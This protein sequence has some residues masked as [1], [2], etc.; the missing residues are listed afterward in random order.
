MLSA[1]AAEAETGTS[2]ASVQRNLALLQARN[3][4]REITGQGRF[5]VWTA[6]L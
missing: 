6:E 2:R 3:L 1:S 5:R 4:I